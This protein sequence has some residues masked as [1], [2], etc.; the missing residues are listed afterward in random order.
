MKN[1]VLESQDGVFLLKVY[2]IGDFA[3][4]GASF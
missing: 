3:V 4:S 1:A 2:V